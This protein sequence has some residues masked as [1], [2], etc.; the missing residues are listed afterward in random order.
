VLLPRRLSRRN[1]GSIDFDIGEPG[2][3]ERVKGIEPSS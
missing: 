1:S 3:L 2:M